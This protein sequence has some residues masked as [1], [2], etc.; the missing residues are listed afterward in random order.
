MNRPQSLTDW[1]RAAYQVAKDHGWHDND[2][3]H[4]VGERIALMH[5]ELSELLEAF[6]R[7]PFARC[8]KPIGLSCAA[9]EVADVF[10]RLADFCAEFEIDLEEAVQIKYEYNKIRPLRHGGKNF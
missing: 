4:R 5:S 6:R 1:S 7:A 3:L 2:G 9:E 8:D 10:L